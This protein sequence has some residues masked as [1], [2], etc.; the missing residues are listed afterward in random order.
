MQKQNK[1][2]LEELG[3]LIRYWILT[4]TTTAGSGHP[5]SS[6]SGVELMTTLF[7]KGFL[8]YDAKNPDDIN[9]DRIIFSK[10]HAA[11]LYYAM[12]AAAGEIEA[13]E[14]GTLRQFWSRLEGHPTLHFPFTDV[15]TGSLGQGLS[16]GLG[17]ALAADR[18]DKVGTYTWVFLGDSEMAEGQVWE[19][20]QLAAHYKCHNL[21]AIVDVNRLGQRGQTMLGH[22]LEIYK[23]RAESFGWNACIVDGHDMDEIQAVYKQAIENTD[24]PTMIFAKTFKGKGISFI[25]DKDSWHGRA[26]NDEELEKALKELGPINEKLRAS[27]AQPIIYK[28]GD[29]STTSETMS[30]DSGE[31]EKSVKMDIYEEKERVSSR[32]AYGNGLVEI[33]RHNKRVIILDAE[34]SN[35]T[36]SAAAKEAFPKRFFEMYI[37]E[38][39][40]ASVA[41]GLSLRGYVP[42]ISSFAAFL[43]RAHDQ[44]RM[45]QFSSAQMVCVGTHPGV[46]IGADGSSQMALEDLALFRAIIGSVVLYPS[47]AT[48]THALTMAAAS[49]PSIVYIR[50]TRES[51]PVLYAPDEEFPIGGSKVL[52][53]SIDDQVTI[54]AAGI[55]VHEALLAYKIL[56]EEDIPVRVIDAYSIKPIDARTIRAAAADTHN[57]VIVEDHYPEGGLGDAVR[58]ALDSNAASITHLAVRKAPRSGQTA[59]LLAYEEIDAQAI[60]RAVRKAL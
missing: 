54:I 2:Q 55:T 32:E 50:A 11:P 30:A 16:V 28:K 22:E 4:M 19:A 24:K 15:A 35:S 42:Y 34:V 9:N 58:A 40:M 53:T 17:M 27:I 29:E 25:E 45:A 41:V 37:A 48:S 56:K 8:R 47:D 33:M 52:C 57:V 6:M 13:E 18:L 21:K 10:G 3:K 7:F 5:S 20:M 51:T 44:I 26:L 31:P 1:E 46:S 23:A 59:E 14:L 12:W 43:S 38:Q 49:L 39:N 36:K 60:V